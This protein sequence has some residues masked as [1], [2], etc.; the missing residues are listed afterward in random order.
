MIKPNFTGG[1]VTV[2]ERSERATRLRVECEYEGCKLVALTDI[3]EGQD[4][5]TELEGF[6]VPPSEE[7][8]ES[9]HGYLMMAHGDLYE[10]EMARICD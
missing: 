6:A 10:T 7:F 1:N 2:V 5:Q 8:V 3:S 4:T 9:L